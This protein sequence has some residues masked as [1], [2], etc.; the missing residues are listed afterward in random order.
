M[1]L[2]WGFLPALAFMLVLYLGCS[3]SGDGGTGPGGSGKTEL[4]IK[5][6]AVKDITDTSAVITWNTTTQTVGTVWY[7]TDSSAMNASRLTPLSTMHNLPIEDLISETTYFFDVVA[8]EPGGDQ[9]KE[10]GNLFT[11]AQAAWM[12]DSTPPMFIRA[13]IEGVTSGSALLV[14]ETDD[15]SWGKVEYGLTTAYG[16]IITES[17]T[18][19]KVYYNNHS[20]IISDLAEDTD[21][22]IRVEAANRRGLT[23]NSADIPFRTLSRPILSISPDTVIVEADEIFTVALHIENAVDIAGLATQISYDFARLQFIQEPM[24]CPCRFSGP[25]SS[26]VCAG[27][28]FCEQGGHIMMPDPIGTLGKI[29][30]EASWYLTMV[31]FI[32]VG[33][34]ADGGGDIA[35]LRFRALLPG[36][37][38]LGFS[39]RDGDQ[40]GK[41]DTR[42]L[43]YNRLPIS[44]R[45][46]T[47]TVI[48]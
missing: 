25:D 45:L 38:T 47:G 9:A 14:W 17:M 30:I 35:Y 7:S 39:E 18:P 1:N 3:I 41:D 13:A 44:F 2:I 20:M 19:E 5:N 15:R 34:E 37:A 27:P 26:N 33:T 6:L 11:T 23:A 16:T 24:Q 40:D 32:P 31:D 29:K 46:E 8:Q 4:E 48:R 22:H 12:N 28:F 43:D 42:L 21:Y 10:K 36:T